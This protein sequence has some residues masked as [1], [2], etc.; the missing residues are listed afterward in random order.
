MMNKVKEVCLSCKHFRLIEVDNGICRVVKKER[1]EEYPVK[2]NDDSCDLWKN[3]GQQYY[4][5][6][7]W[8][9]KSS[10]PEAAN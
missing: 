10:Q 6:L 5:R 9:K 1:V 7:G 3:C 4:I 8:I 2:K